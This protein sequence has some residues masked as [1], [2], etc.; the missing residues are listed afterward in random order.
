MLDD[1]KYSNIRKIEHGDDPV[2]LYT[3]KDTAGE[4][5]YIYFSHEI[6]LGVKTFRKLRHE[7]EEAGGTHL[8]LISKEGLTPFASKEL[9]DT[10]FSMTIEII[11]KRDLCTC[12][13]HHRLVPP[14]I[15]LTAQEKKQLLTKMS[16]GPTALAKIRESDAVV[17]YMNFQR[18]T[19][20]K[21]IRQIGTLEAETTYRI[22][23]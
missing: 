11:K 10:E 15:P 9:N 12:V 3:C 1:R 22:V 16:A 19:V 6:K 4:I 21:I 23:V 18:G 5:T 20:L 2:L 14:H 7:C 17:K 13:I 8:I